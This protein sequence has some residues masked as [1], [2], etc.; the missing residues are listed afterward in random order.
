[1][2]NPKNRELSRQG[3]I[4]QWE[5][6]SEKEKQ[7]RAEGMRQRAIK[8]N[9]DPIIKENIAKKLR[10]RV[11]AHSTIYESVNACAEA[12]GVKANTITYRCQTE[13]GVGKGFR[14]L[15]NKTE[16]E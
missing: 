6:M 1:M 5:N 8:L 12:F 16:G 13:N 15:N 7:S 4:K 3:A 10:K 11:I 9:S 2:S 14:Y